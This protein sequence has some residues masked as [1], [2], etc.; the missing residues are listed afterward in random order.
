[1]FIIEEG[2]CVVN[3]AGEGDVARLGR[4][5]YFGEASLLSDVP[6]NATISAASDLKAFKVAICIEIDE[7]L[8]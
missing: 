5:K 3:I 6:R 7:F 4:G 2:E 8:Y 1:M